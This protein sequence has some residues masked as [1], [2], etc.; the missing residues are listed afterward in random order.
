MLVQ[1]VLEK[2]DPL[3]P[4]RGD[5]LADI[6]GKLLEEGEDVGTAILKEGN[7]G[8]DDQPGKEGIRA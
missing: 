6:G 1:V 5:V 3:L 7:G 2:W 8:Q 4:Q